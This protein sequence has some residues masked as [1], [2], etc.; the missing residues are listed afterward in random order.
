MD[1]K[2]TTI[3]SAISILVFAVLAVVSIGCGSTQLVD[4]WQDPAF[5]QRPMDKVLVVAMQKDDMRRRLWEDAFVE[6]MLERDEDINAVPSYTLFPEN[7]PDT[8]AVREG[9]GNRGF[10]GVLLITGIAKEEYL[11]K[12]PGYYSEQPVSLYSPWWNTYVTRYEVVYHPG[13]LERETA[14]RVAADMLYTNGDGRLV[15]SAVSETVDPTSRQQLKNSVSD[16]MVDD[17]ADANLIP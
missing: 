12:Y 8:A 11:L 16:V 2:H 14:V 3:T 6:T 15:W 9:V 5:E 13:Y 10:D 1:K 17:L 4:V 7:F